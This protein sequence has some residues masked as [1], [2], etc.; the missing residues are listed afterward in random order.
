MGSKRPPME[1][2]L[3]WKVLEVLLELF[4]GLERWKSW[5]RGF[6]LESQWS[7]LEGALAP[8]TMGPSHTSTI[9]SC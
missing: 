4:L 3:L 9:G 7:F 2:S 8:S 5:L 6:W 1:K